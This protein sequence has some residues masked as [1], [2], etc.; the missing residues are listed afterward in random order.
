MPCLEMAWD[1]A[2]KEQ[3]NNWAVANGVQELVSQD[4]LQDQVSIEAPSTSTTT[5]V[6]IVIVGLL[7]IAASVVAVIKRKACLIEKEKK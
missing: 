6:V 1:D 2:S 5:L 3:C 4:T 7:I